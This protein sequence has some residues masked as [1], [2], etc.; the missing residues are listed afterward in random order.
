MIYNNFERFRR[1][2]L[3]ESYMN[4]NDQFVI[5]TIDRRSIVNFFHIIGVAMKGQLKLN[6]TDLFIF[7]VKAKWLDP[8]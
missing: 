2:S 5:R 1:Q 3:M 7:N 4:V 8:S 6:H